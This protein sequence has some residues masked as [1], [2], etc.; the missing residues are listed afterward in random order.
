MDAAWA[1]VRTY[2]ANLGWPN[3][4]SREP[5]EQGC[6]LFLYEKPDRWMIEFHTPEYEKHL[7]EGGQGWVI[8]LKR[9]EALH[10]RLEPEERA[11]LGL[12]VIGLPSSSLSRYYRLGT[13]PTAEDRRVLGA[14]S[15]AL[16]L[17]SI[18]PGS[19]PIRRAVLFLD[20]R[21]YLPRKVRLQ[22][23]SGEELRITLRHPVRDENL[24]PSVWTVAFPPGTEVVER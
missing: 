9:K 5:G 15:P 7:L 1:R 19:V 16:V 6:G 14:A 11:R 10:Y 13:R 3:P 20:S 22:L 24:D 12:M 17:E 8:S 4:A 18:E 21:S 2:Q 23:E